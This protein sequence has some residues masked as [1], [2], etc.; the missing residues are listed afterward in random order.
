MKTNLCE[1]L[2]EDWKRTYKLKT[3]YVYPS[4]SSDK[5]AIAMIIN[6]IKQLKPDLDSPKMQE[7]VNWYFTNCFEF[8]PKWILEN[9]DLKIINSKF[10]SIYKNIRSANPAKIYAENNY[11]ENYNRSGNKKTSFSINEPTQ[12]T[13]ILKSISTGK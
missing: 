4:D 12:L 3:G 7:A 9:I 1:L 13:E 5:K 8:A 11:R 10:A 2:L 6:K